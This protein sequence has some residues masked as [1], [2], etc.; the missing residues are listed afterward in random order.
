MGG[1]ERG[2]K[3]MDLEIN[4]MGMDRGVWDVYHSWWIGGIVLLWLFF[5]YCLINFYGR[6][7]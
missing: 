6:E 2:G 4:G 7:D 5:W 3:R 1:L